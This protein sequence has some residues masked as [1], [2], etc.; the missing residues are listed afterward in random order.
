MRKLIIAGSITMLAVIAWIS[1]LQYDI[2]KF[3]SDL[4]LNTPEQQVKS[5]TKDALE[6]LPDGAD[7]VVE[8]TQ[9]ESENTLT[10]L[11]ERK[12]EGAAQTVE[13]DA[14]ALK[15]DKTSEN[16]G[17][18]SENIG[19][20]PEIKLFFV[21]Y[22]AYRKQCMEVN[23]KLTPVAKQYASIIDQ[24]TNIPDNY[25]YQ[26]SLVVEDRTNKLIKQLETVGSV[27]MPLQEERDRVY[28]EGLKLFSEQGFASEEEF[29][30]AYGEIYDTWE[31]DPTTY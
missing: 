21:A 30:T 7:G 24:I 20:S 2:K 10:G 12:M 5:T 23:D 11:P 3:R 14:D 17:Q 9:A 27:L 25:S 28:E 1:Y 31:A 19:L 13:N 6:T 8:T 4:S 26:E 15:N 16:I 22:K 18:A 29:R